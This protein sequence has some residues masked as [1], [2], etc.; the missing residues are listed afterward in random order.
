MHE[1]L[2][3][4]ID[5]AIDKAN[6]P[7]NSQENNVKKIDPAIKLREEID[8]LKQ[9]NSSLLGQL[10]MLEERYRNTDYQ[11][12]Q[13]MIATLDCE[14]YIVTSIL[15]HQIAGSHKSFLDL[16]KRFEAKYHGS[17]KLKDAQEKIQYL[18]NEIESSKI[19]PLIVKSPK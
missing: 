6:K 9:E 3:N 14:L 10:V 2:L 18:Q 17:G 16:V 15:N 8:E 7:K 1:E 13:N 4:E 5:D 12:S 11:Y 19:T